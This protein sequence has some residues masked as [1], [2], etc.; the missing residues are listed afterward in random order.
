VALT[1]SSERRLHPRSPANTRAIL[2]APGVEM[3][4][5]ILDT[6]AGGLRVRTDRQMSLPAQV[7]IVDLSAGLALETDVAWRKGAEAGLRL[8]SQSSLRGL[9]PARLVPAR[10][11]WLRAGGR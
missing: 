1:Q 7:M 8:K 9:V 4:C 10:E 5:V 2:V 11:A 6:S 3:A